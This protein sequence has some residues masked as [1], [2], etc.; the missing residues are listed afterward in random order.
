[1]INLIF[2]PGDYRFTFQF[3]VVKIFCFK[4]LS[5]LPNDIDYLHLHRSSKRIIG[6]VDGFFKDHFHTRYPISF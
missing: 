1:M 6:K 4:T 2:D 5:F 3:F